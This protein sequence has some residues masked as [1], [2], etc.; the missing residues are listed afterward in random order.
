MT[1]RTRLSPWPSPSCMTMAAPTCSWIPPSARPNCWRIWAIRCRC[2][3]PS[4]FAAALDA[5]KGKSV[6][7]DPATAAAAIF[8]RLTK[9]GA[10]IKQGA[11]PCQLPKAC[12]NPPGNRRHAQGAHPRR[13][14]A[15]ALSGL[16][17]SQCRGRRADR[18]PGGRNPGRLPPRHR[19]AQ[20][21]VVRHHFRRGQQRRHRALPGDALHQPHHPPERDVPAGFAARNIPT[22][23]PT[24]PA[25]SW[26]ASRRRKC[27]TVSPGC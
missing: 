17:R 24:S 22:A 7:V 10:K 4:H 2:M 8:D 6:L 21:R 14:G 5:M 25:P 19:R 15:G 11:D 12:K 23:P 9:A 1:C 26:W 18:N 27:A 16:V 20:R 13:R 3:S